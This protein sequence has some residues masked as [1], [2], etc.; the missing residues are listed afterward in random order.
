MGSILSQSAARL[1]ISIVSHGHGALLAAL[2][3]DIVRWRQ[4]SDIVVVTLN[5]AE[6]AGFATDRWRDIEWIENVTPKGFA[7]NH[8]MALRGRDA[9]WYAVLNPDLRLP[10]DMLALLTQ[11]VAALHAGLAVPV[12]VDHD[13]V[14]QDSARALLTP[15]RLAGRVVQRLVRRRQPGRLTSPA[16]MDWVAGMAMVFCHKAFEAVG[17]FDERYF[18]YCEDM[19]LCLRL[20]LAGYAIVLVPD[21]TVIH[22]ARRASHHSGRHLRWHLASLLRFWCSRAFWS[23]WLR[24]HQVRKVSRAGP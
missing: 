23:Y 11:R 14:P 21:T 1:A 3:D 4:P 10:A 19:D 24:R 20:Q 16:A 12:V 22:D 9:Y 8:N 18:L 6:D 13:G 2:L 5:I 7:A 17:G 15:L